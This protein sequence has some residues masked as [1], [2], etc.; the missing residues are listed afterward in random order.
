MWILTADKAGNSF[1]KQLEVNVDTNNPSTNIIFYGQGTN[2]RFYKNVEIRLA[3]SDA[4]SGVKETYY[5][6]DDAP[7]GFNKYKQPMTIDTIGEHTI[8]YYSID[9]I[10]NQEEIKT[11]TFTISNINFDL[12]ITQPTNGIYIFGKRLIP[13]QKTIIIGP[14]E[15]KA[16]TNTFT[17][18][19]ANISKIEFLID[20]TIKNT[21]T[22]KPYTY[23]IDQQLIGKHTIE[24]K[25]YTNNNQDTVTKSIQAT[26]IIL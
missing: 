20:G 18:E 6:I 21:T 24:V 3:G 26:F 4:G 2:N 17:E 22:Q 16:T 11:T 1:E 5:K 25:A 14:T 7:I 19:P 10:G 8:E 12:E 23:K 9:N 13:I 15:I